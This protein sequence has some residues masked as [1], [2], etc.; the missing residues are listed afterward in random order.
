MK[1]TIRFGFSLILA[2]LTSMAS[3][4]TA[5]AS[6]TT[7]HSGTICHAYNASQATLVDYFDYGTRNIATY[8]LPVVCPLVRST[9]NSAGA[10]ADVDV[11]TFSNQT[12]SC[13]FSSYPWN[14]NTPKGTVT[15]SWT[16]TGSHEFSMTLPSGSSDFWS[17]YSVRCTL[18]PSGSGVLKDVDL[19]EY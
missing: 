18:P 12:I 13:T 3:V 17:T 7:D 9:N 6:V 16:G 15:Q 19:I 1:L 2:W 4:Q 10:T 8:S 11:F 14:S 5:Q